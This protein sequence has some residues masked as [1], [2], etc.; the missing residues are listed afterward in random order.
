M[1]NKIDHFCI[2]EIDPNTHKYHL[3]HHTLAIL[4]TQKKHS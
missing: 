1:Q 4:K 2:Y 3:Y